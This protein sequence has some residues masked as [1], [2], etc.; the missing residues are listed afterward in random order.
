MEKELFE[1]RFHLSMQST[2]YERCVLLVGGCNDYNRWKGESQ[3][4]YKEPQSV[5]SEEVK[6]DFQ[7]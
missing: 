2:Y 1:Q 3:A 4:K 7:A 6:L 5:H